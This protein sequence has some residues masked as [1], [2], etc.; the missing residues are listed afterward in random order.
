MGPRPMWGWAKYGIMSVEPDGLTETLQGSDPQSDRD[1]L[2]AVAARNERRW[3][4]T[5]ST[6]RRRAWPC[7]GAHSRQVSGTET[8]R[9]PGKYVRMAQPPRVVERRAA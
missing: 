9:W 1:D 8:F 2:I 7:H 3:R 4:Q 5:T 6:E